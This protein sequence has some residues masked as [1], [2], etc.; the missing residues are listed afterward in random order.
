[1]PKKRVVVVANKWWECDPMMNV[2]LHDFARDPDALG[3]P[4]P[5]NHPRRRPA[6]PPKGKLPDENPS[7][8]PRAVF[9]MSNIDAEVWCISDLLEHLPDALKYQS[10]SEVKAKY[11]PRIFAAGPAPSLVVAFGTAGYPDD[12]T[13]N[14][15]VV[16][17][18]GIFMHNCHPNGENGESNWSAGSF[19]AVIPSSLDAATFNALTVIETSP[20]PSVMSR[21]IIEPLNPTPLTLLLARSDYVAVGALNVTDYTEYAKTDDLALGAFK[22]TNNV[23]LARSLETTHGLIRVQSDA[24]FVFVSG[25]TDRVGH[26]KEE[27][28]PRSYAQNFGAAH[29]AGIV[30]AWMLVRANVVLG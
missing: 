3:W 17:G 27:V 1:M 19:D 4:E 23:S 10:S 21:F 15:S 18:S 28:F 12:A 14:G 6:Q 5:L 29:N 2:L 24:P 13:Q 7:P 26:F 25:I 16:V 8:A 30:L 20:K 22:A 9:R 11:I